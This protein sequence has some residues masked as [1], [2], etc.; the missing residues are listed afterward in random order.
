MIPWNKPNKNWKKSG[1]KSKN[2]KNRVEQIATERIARLFELAESE[3][4]QHPKRSHRYVQLALKI[5]TR[6]RARVPL[7]L[8][9]QYCKKCHSF[10]KQNQNAVLEQNKNGWKSSA[11]TA[12]PGSNGKPCQTRLKAF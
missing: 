11:K 3:F 8:K 5:S 7:E 6:N 1:M 12:K 9:T 10:L 4:E 2:Q